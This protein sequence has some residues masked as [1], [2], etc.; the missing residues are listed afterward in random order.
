MLCKLPVEN[1]INLDRYRLD[2]DNDDCARALIEQAH[3]RLAQDGACVFPDFLT[4][5]G[6]AGLALEAQ[7]LS[8][9]A[10]PSPAA[11]TPYYGKRAE[12]FPKGHPR[13]TRQIADMGLVADF[14]VPGD[15]AIRR[16]YEWGRLRQFLAGVLEVDQL[17]TFC[18]PCQTVNISVIDEGGQ[19]PWHFDSGRFT[20]TLL[21]QAA[22]SGGDFEYVPRLRDVDD[23]N[24]AG[25]AQILSGARRAGASSDVRTRLLVR[26]S[27]GAFSA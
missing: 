18:D 8:D 5:A 4:Q 16:L 23:E 24:Y 1:L 17:F 26:F 19:Q 9:L 2:E 22:E 11:V 27:R 7:T 6:V 13:Q 15:A 12:E 21:L 25:V 14:N 10:W 20:V 3:E